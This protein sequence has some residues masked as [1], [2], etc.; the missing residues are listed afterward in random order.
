MALP[1][2]G[3]AITGARAKLSISTDSGDHEIGWAMG[4]S[5]QEQ[6]QQQPVNVLGLIDP[7]EIEPV[8]RSITVTCDY[9]RITS[10]SLQSLGVWP[11]HSANDTVATQTVL[12]FGD[13]TATI[14]DITDDSVI[15]KIEGMRPQ[16]RSFRVDRGGIMT[17]NSQFIARH[18]YDQSNAG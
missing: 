5:V 1:N 7:V 16:S 2:N 8:S 3:R 18:M 15:Y 13:L 14:Y 9:V 6:I 10:E 4:V 17:V 11:G 12:S